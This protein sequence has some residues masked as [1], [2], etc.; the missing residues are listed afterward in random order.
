MAADLLAARSMLV[1]YGGAAAR[2]KGRQWAPK[3]G[4]SAERMAQPFIEAGKFHWAYG[5]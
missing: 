1:S 4:A 5:A 2:I 3:R